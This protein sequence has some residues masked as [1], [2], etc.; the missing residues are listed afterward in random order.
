[1]ALFKFWLV[2]KVLV[3]Q[4]YGLDIGATR[5]H[6]VTESKIFLCTLGSP[7]NLGVCEVH[8]EISDIAFEAH[9]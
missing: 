2:L 3:L 5:L 8:F 4:Y 1:M 6:L 7:D 9:V